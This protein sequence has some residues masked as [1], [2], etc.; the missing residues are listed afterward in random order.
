[1][2]HVYFA[3][4]HSKKPFFNFHL[5]NGETD[6]HVLCVCKQNGTNQSVT[7]RPSPDIKCYVAQI[8]N[9]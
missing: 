9:S 7:E 3:N 6:V 2:Y 1:M 5:I 4:I 8:K